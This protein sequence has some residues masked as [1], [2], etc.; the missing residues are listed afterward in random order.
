MSKRATNLFIALFVASQLAMPM[1][2]YAG[3]RTFDERFAWRM[4]SPIRVTSCDVRWYEGAT[5]TRVQ[6]YSE[7]G[8]PW[9]SLM[10][11]ARE[12]VIVAYARHRCAQMRGRH[13]QPALRVHVA[14][15]HPDGQ[16]RTLATPF[17][18]LCET[19]R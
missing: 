18:N 14:C 16:R 15:D 2:Y 7:I 11:R 5:R 4:F 1:S 8:A 10:A 17:V 19:L 9:V 3:D 12:S 13:E 6:P